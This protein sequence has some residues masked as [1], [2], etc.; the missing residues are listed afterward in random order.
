MKT[1]SGIKGS[2]VNF[3]STFTRQRTDFTIEFPYKIS[4]KHGIVIEIDGPH[5]WEN[6]SQMILDGQRETAAANAGW[7]NTLRIQT[8]NFVNIQSQV[9][10][11]KELS[12]E[13]YFQILKQNFATPFYQNETGLKTLQVV[14]SPFANLSGINK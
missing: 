6:Q 2:F 14:L 4:D 8:R 10:R 1:V 11:L 13:N 7:L 9:S 3:D 12:K 5:H